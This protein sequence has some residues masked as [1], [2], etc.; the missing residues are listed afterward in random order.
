M[1][2]K[3]HK[4][5]EREREREYSCLSFTRYASLGQ[6]FFFFVCE[7]GKFIEKETNKQ[8]YDNDHNDNTIFFQ[9]KND[10]IFIY[11]R[12]VYKFVNWPDL[13]N[14]FVFGVK[15]CIWIEYGS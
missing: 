11:T 9:E 7:E 4:Q 6:S 14:Y 12:K 10:I 2:L 5:I 1:W 13:V 8:N 15:I 3:M